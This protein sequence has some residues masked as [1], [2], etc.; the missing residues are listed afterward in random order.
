MGGCGVV[1][2]VWTIC[3]HPTTRFLCQ[4]PIQTVSITLVLILVL[5]GGIFTRQIIQWRTLASTQVL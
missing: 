3:D 4:R 2:P 1:E 5:P